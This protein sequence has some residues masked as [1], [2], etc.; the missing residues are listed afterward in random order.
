MVFHKVLVE[1]HVSTS[2]FHC[3]YHGS[4]SGSFTYT[5]AQNLNFHLKKGNYIAV[6]NV[7]FPKTSKSIEFQMYFGAYSDQVD[8]TKMKTFTA[9]FYSMDELCRILSTFAN[10]Y[11]EQNIK[12]VT[13]QKQLDSLQICDDFSSPHREHVCSNSMDIENTLLIKYEYG[14]FTI[15]VNPEL[16]LVISSNLAR[17]LGMKSAMLDSYTITEKLGKSE[18]ELI[19]NCTKLI[20]FQQAT[21]FYRFV[22]DERCFFNLPKEKN[23]S[24]VFNDIIESFCILKNGSRFNIFFQYD[25]DKPHATSDIISVRE[26]VT[27]NIKSLKFTVYDSNMDACKFNFDPKTN[28]IEFTLVFFSN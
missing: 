15:A 12:N 19:K 20:K 28:P 9:N 6:K 27:E 8:E 3:D 5:L 21:K 16:K 24:F 7:H 10:N 22:S 4:G 11:F 1:I 2:S 23:I 17:F 18:L 14:K 13:I 26:L 25:L